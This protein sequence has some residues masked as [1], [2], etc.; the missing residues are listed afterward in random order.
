[1]LC[2]EF[3]A[4]DMQ[5]HVCVCGVRGS[6][7]TLPSLFIQVEVTL[8]GGGG[9]GMQRQERPLCMC[10]A[11]NSCMNSGHLDKMLYSW[12]LESGVLFWEVTLFMWE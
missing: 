4:R 5:Q 6:I 8:V 3:A 11:Q 10:C 2:E 1:M 12:I 9:T 7:W